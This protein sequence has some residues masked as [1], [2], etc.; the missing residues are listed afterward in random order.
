[1]QAPPPQ[2]QYNSAFG[3][4]SANFV[5][6]GGGGGGQRRGG[7]Q[8]QQHSITASHN[9][10]RGRGNSAGDRADR[11]NANY[12]PQPPPV[13]GNNFSNGGNQRTQRFAGQSHRGKVGRT[14]V[15]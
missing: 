4:G 2:S 11:R 1:M 12:L 7:H 8:Q 13:S 10:P 15:H 14:A 3:G 5:G 9:A 6:V